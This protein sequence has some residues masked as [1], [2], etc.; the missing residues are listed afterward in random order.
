MLNKY[1]GG[2][3]QSTAPYV[4]L[5]LCFSLFR[6]RLWVIVTVSDVVTVTP[7][8][9]QFVYIVFYASA[10]GS[11]LS[12]RMSV[13]ATTSGDGLSRRVSYRPFPARRVPLALPRATSSH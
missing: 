1:T 3:R 12:V 10:A 9:A 13:I 2:G 6:L 7:I 8:C 4:H 11:V 5:F